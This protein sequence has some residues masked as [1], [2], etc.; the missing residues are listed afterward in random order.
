MTEKIICAGFGGQGIMLL[1][2]LLAAAALIEGKH[3]TWMPSYGAEVRGGTAHSMIIISDEPV[4]S[5]V[6]KD[7]TSCIVMNGPSYKKFAKRVQKRGLLI[8]NS[9]LVKDFPKTNGIDI[10][11]APFTEMASELGNVRVANMIAAGAYIAKKQVISRKSLE[12]ALKAI[13]PLNRTKLLDLNKK[14]IEKGMSQ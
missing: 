13:L 2:K 1:G 12:K 11:S 9:S 10:V 6:V 7:P 8:I 3:T 14:A 4:A 5:P